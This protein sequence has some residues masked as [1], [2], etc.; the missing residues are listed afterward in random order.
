MVNREP[1]SLH[2]PLLI[3]VSFCFLF[4]CHW[5]GYG[6]SF[7]CRKLHLREFTSISFC[8]LNTK[9]LYDFEVSDGRW[10]KTSIAAR[11][12]FQ[13]HSNGISDSDMAWSVGKKWSNNRTELD[14]ENWCEQMPAEQRIPK[15]L[16][17]WMQSNAICIF[18]LK[19]ISVVGVG[20]FTVR[21]SSCASSDTFCNW[22]CDKMRI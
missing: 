2:I 10:K 9:M 12:H 7:L 15:R 21:T 6:K 3:A 17:F 20:P 14:M 18:P 13:L 19:I 5:L 1:P 22:N 8:A 4:A 16:S 11:L